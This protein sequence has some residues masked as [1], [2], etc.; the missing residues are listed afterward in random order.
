MDHLLS[1]W[2]WAKFRGPQLRQWIYH[3]LR[4]DPL[5]ISNLSK[6]DRKTLDERM[7][8]ALGEVVTKQ[9]SADG[10]W[11]ILV[12]LRHWIQWLKRW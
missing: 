9:L 11:K 3:T 1:E 6:I 4:A 12:K 8:F 2:G 10:T 5:G 7:D